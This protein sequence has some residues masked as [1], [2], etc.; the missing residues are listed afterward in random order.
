MLIGAQMMEANN[1]TSIS[2]LSQTDHY[3]PDVVSFESGKGHQQT[4]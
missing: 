2:P 3:D 1:L 4:L